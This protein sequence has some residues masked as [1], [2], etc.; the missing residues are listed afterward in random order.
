MTRYKRALLDRLTKLEATV[1]QIV[2]SIEKIEVATIVRDP[3][4][5]LSVEAYDGLR[6]QVVA[7][8]G[9]R[10][11]HLHQLARFAEAAAA[12]AVIDDLGPLIEEW[13]LQAG[14]ERLSDPNDKRYFD[15]LGGDGN[16]L[17][18]LRP[19]YRDV[20]TGRPIIMGQ[21]ER[22]TPEAVSVSV[23]DDLFDANGHREETR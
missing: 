14:V 9:E 7:A 22:V 4:S 18:L 3:S 13:M 21:A 2:R 10:M 17:R 15:V 1:D 12:A 6:K 20:A 23:T 5:A 11:A 16:E 8:A 19:A